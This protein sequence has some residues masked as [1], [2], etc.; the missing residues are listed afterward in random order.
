MKSICSD[1]VKSFLRMTYQQKKSVIT[2]TFYVYFNVHIYRLSVSW[3]KEERKNSYHLYMNFISTYERQSVT[4]TIKGISILL[5]HIYGNHDL[6]IM[7]FSLYISIKNDILN[8]CL[9]AKDVYFIRIS[10]YTKFY[11]AKIKNF[12]TVSV[13]PFII[14]DICVAQKALSISLFSYQYKTRKYTIRVQ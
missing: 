3:P 12:H 7:N 8:I 2:V 10:I 13:S 9:P 4:L 6:I 1:G 14:N 5:P 11:T